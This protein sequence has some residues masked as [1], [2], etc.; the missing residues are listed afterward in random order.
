MTVKQEKLFYDYF[1]LTKAKRWLG[2]GNTPN[3]IGRH[4]TDISA[5]STALICAIDEWYKRDDKN[6]PQH[7]SLLTQECQDTLRSA[8][9]KIHDLINAVTTDVMKGNK[10]E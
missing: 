1:T 4:H 3:F 5:I 7:I 9:I 10:G 8:E 2:N 6:V